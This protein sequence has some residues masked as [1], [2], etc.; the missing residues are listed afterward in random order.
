MLVS[1]QSFPFGCQNIAKE[2]SLSEYL[3]ITQKEE[4]DSYFSRGF[5]YEVKNKQPRLEF[6]LGSLCR[7]PKLIIDALRVSI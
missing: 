4:K 5:K 3:P 2:F 1:I 7:F 6:E